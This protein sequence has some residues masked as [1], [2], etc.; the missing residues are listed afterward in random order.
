[1]IQFTGYGA[2]SIDFVVRFWVERPNF[3]ASSTETV[4]RS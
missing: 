2:S 3:I 1:M 4:K